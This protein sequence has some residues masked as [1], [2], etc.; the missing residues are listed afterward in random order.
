MRGDQDAE[1]KGGDDEKDQPAPPA[2]L[3]AGKTAAENVQEY[4][5]EPER[6][7]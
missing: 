3:L 6:G 4:P 2:G 1:D 7:C 5:A